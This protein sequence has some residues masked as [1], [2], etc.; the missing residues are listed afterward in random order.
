MG[1]VLMIGGLVVGSV[2]IRTTTCETSLHDCEVLIRQCKVDDQF[3]L[4]V[5][6]ESLELLHII[7]IHLSCLDVG[8][9]FATNFNPEINIR[10]ITQKGLYWEDGKWVETAPLEI[11]KPL[12]Y[13][14]VGPKES[15]LLHHE[16]I[17]SLVKNYPTIK[18][19][20]FWIY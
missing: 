14:E 5:V 10:E 6:E 20:R 1:K 9:A 8:K 16:E 12:T 19:A 4:I 11:H 7:S 15:Y 2:E 13:P 3:R 17:E 18:R